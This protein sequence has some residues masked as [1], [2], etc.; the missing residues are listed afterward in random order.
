MPNY[1]AALDIK[2]I[3]TLVFAAVLMFGLLTYIYYW[4]AGEHWGFYAITRSYGANKNIFVKILLAVADT[5]VLPLMV[6]FYAPLFFLG[7]L[8]HWLF[9]KISN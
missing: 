4:I 5:L 3:H 8:C 6:F 1:L 9:N 2:T 7:I